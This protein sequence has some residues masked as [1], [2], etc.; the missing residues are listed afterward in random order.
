MIEWE[1]VGLTPRPA[2][3]VNAASFAVD[4]VYEAFSFS[5]CCTRRRKSEVGCLLPTPNPLCSTDFP[6]FFLMIIL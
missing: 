1:R 5:G 3:L 2:S 4:N 6:P